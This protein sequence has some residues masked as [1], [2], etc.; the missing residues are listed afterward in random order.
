[1]KIAVETLITNSS[2]IILRKFRN[3]DIDQLMQLTS[4]RDVMQHIGGQMTPIETRSY[5]A[6][7]IQNR[8]ITKEMFALIYKPTMKFAGI[9]GFTNKNNA[10]PEIQVAVLKKYQRKGLAKEA[11]AFCTNYATKVL[12]K[13]TVVVY[14]KSGN[15][16]AKKV[17]RKVDFKFKKIEYKSGRSQEMYVF[18]PSYLLN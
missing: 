6:T 14:L 9:A 7:L 8:D 10:Y 18:S 1:M 16:I 3:N 2:K 15:N 12:N 17:M 4:D 5:L 13:N 11:F